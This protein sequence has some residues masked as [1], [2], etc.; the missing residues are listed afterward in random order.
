MKWFKLR[1]GAEFVADSES[2]SLLVNEDLSEQASLQSDGEHHTS[3]LTVCLTVTEDLTKYQCVVM[4]RGE[5]ISRETIVKVK[6][7]KQKHI[8][9]TEF[10]Y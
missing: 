4:C 7:E 3:V 9:I 10:Y 2:V 6:G 1:S 8:I 5:S